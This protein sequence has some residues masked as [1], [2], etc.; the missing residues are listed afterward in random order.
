MNRGS[1]VLEADPIKKGNL[2]YLVYERIVDLILSGALQPGETLTVA[3]LA[4]AFGVSPMPVREALGRLVSAN[5]LEVISG[6]S[7]GIPALSIERLDDLRRVRCEIEG[8]AGTWATY[9]LRGQDIA[10][11]AG[12]VTEMDTAIE[13]KDHQSF[14]RLNRQFHFGIYSKAGSDALLSLIEP[15]WLQVSPY[16]NVLKDSE[17]YPA[18]NDRHKAIIKALSKKDGS[19]VGVLIQTDINEAARYLTLELEALASQ[20]AGGRKRRA[21]VRRNS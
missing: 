13:A 11:L 14:V 18:S 1:P 12:W 9:N 10:Q 15:L 7:L 2:Q 17:N 5:V 21:Y 4:E 6:R 19:M 16:F 3:T 20:K 8:I